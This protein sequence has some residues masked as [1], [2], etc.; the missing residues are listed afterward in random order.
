MRRAL[1]LIVVLFGAALAFGYPLLAA[2][3]PSKSVAS[4]PVYTPGSGF[5]PVETSLH[6]ENAPFRIYIDLT[7]AGSTKFDDRAVLTLTVSTSGKTVPTIALS[8]T[9]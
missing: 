4:Y 8:G 2:R 3:L 9:R 1:S 7:A 5:V 6:P